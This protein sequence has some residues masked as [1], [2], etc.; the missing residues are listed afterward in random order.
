MIKSVQLFLLSTLLVTAAC[1]TSKTTPNDATGSAG[2]TGSAGS[3]GTTGSAGAGGASGTTGAAGTG[4]ATGTAGA[5]GGA[6]TSGS[7]AAAGTTDAPGSD[8]GSDVATTS[9]GGGSDAVTT[10]KAITAAIGGTLTVTGG[11]INIPA[12]ALAA[13][14]M[15]TVKESVPA[16]DTPNK[17]QINGLIYDFGP[18]GTKFKTP[19]ELMLPLTGAVP[20]GKL[21]VIAFLDTATNVWVP[22]GSSV[23]GAA[24]AQKVDAL[25]MHF[26]PF[27]VLLVPTGGI[28]P[29]TAA[30]GGSLV[31]TWEIT[32]F[33]HGGPQESAGVDCKDGTFQF[34]RAVWDLTGTMTIAADNSYSFART[35][36]VDRLVNDP[37]GCIAL[38][39][40]I[41]NP[42]IALCDDLVPG[43]NTE[44]SLTTTTCAGSIAAGCTCFSPTPM[45]LTETGTIVPTGTTYIATKTGGQP[46]APD[47]YCVK[48][49]VLTVTTANND[50]YTAIKK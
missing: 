46:G 30:C 41:L 11:S 25:T 32:T 10:T 13:D 29:S 4:G 15:I 49:N 18:N 50:V 2:T 47:S 22:L 7:D 8:G 44:F 45:A 24:G 19:V 31:G 9:D 33:C 40:T 38:A 26:T 12:G 37:P 17:D 14:A 27:A 34:A 6:G 3:G 42:K 48:G 36:H 21:A 43:L 23:V 35:I 20:A 28:C 39:N 16:S 5:D 1:G